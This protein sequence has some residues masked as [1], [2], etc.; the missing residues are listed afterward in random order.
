MLCKLS[1]PPGFWHNCINRRA[2]LTAGRLKAKHKICF[3]HGESS[4]VHGEAGV[5]PLGHLH[6][7]PKGLDWILSLLPIPASC[8]GMLLEAADDELSTW[9]PETLKDL[10]WVLIPRFDLVQTWLLQAFGELTS[11]QQMSLALSVS[12]PV[13]WS[14]EKKENNLQFNYII[15]NYASILIFAVKSTYLLILLFCELFR[16][17]HIPNAHKLKVICTIFLI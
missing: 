6:P 12:L 7:L 9:V 5:C 10:D 2:C 17:P 15:K 1:I 16:Y 8:R 13:K 4:T 3:I 11:W 14:T